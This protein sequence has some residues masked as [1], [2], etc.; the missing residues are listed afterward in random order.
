MTEQSYVD[1][2]TVDRELTGKVRTEKAALSEAVVQLVDTAGHEI[3]RAV[4]EAD[5]M[6][7]LPIPDGGQFLLLAT[8][9]GYQ[10]VIDLVD[11]DR[12]TP[13][14]IVLERFSSG[15]SGVVRDQRSGR[16]I[17][18]RCVQLVDGRGITVRRAITAADG[19]YEFPAIPTGDYSIVVA[20]FDPAASSA[21]LPAG[22]RTELDLHL[23]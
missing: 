14:D 11:A 2:S 23:D 17:G 22:E 3:E 10:P 16:P 8:A 19:R 9:E 13:R 20:G 1:K 21:S 5:G 18:D 15:I 6:F 4:T 7:R 12:P